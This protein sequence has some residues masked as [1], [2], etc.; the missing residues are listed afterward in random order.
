MQADLKV[1]AVIPA[2]NSAATISRALSSVIAQ[3]R[4]PDEIIVVDD[5][6]TDAT[7]DI[8]SA[9]ACSRI[10]VIGTHMRRG[11]G[12]AR[13]AGIAAAQGDI[14]AFLDSDD[15][16]LPV[17]L[18]K[19]VDM[20]ASDRRLSFVACAAHSISADGADLGDTYG[21]S[22]ISTGSDA[23]KALLACNFVATPSVIVWR[24]HLLALNGFD[25]TM[26]IGEDQDLWV[27]LALAG[28]L[29]YVPDTLVR[30]H[31]RND[32]LSS[33]MLDDLLTFTMPMIER[34]LA[35]QSHRLTRADIRRIR[36]ERLNRFGRVAYV[37]GD[38]IRGARLIAS[39][40][41]LGY[42]PVE[43][44]LYLLRAAPPLMWAKRQLGAAA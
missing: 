27:K 2:Y 37:R 3:T 23:W 33:W 21:M 39:S 1:S 36:G 34:H 9:T 19:Q 44:T 40:M 31:L 35:R 16:W 7:R 24:R 14:V 30:V 12:G 10:R 20:L 6:S 25:E 13:N 38:I 29:G 15:E 11:A 26:K 32:S 28:S 17:K 18:E 41:M 8:A 43:S 5:C 22:R 4:P 42:Q